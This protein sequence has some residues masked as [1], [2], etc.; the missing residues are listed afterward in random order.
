MRK[1]KMIPDRRII[2][3]TAGVLPQKCQADPMPAITI[4]S[5]AIANIVLFFFRFRRRI[6][7]CSIFCR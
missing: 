4:S 6:R 1:I 3:I 5:L 2:E 7:N